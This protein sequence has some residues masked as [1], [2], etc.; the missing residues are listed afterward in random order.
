MDTLTNK[1]AIGIFQGI[2]ELEAAPGVRMNT[3]ALQAL[4]MNQAALEPIVSGTDRQVRAL[5]EDYE[6]DLASA[7]P[8]PEE[9]V[10]AHARMLD[11]VCEPVALR[12]VKQDDL[13]L[14]NA[15]VKVSTY[16]KLLPIIEE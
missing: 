8:H 7:D 13:K 9:F 15:Q 1:T 4:A 6:V 14:D 5:A 3:K 11:E 10:E 2:R 12:K 16:R